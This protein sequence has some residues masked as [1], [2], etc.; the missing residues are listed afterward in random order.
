MSGGYRLQSYDEGGNVLGDSVIIDSIEVKAPRRPP[1]AA[2]L[3]MTQEVMAVFPEA[4]VTLLGYSQPPGQTKLPGQ[5][6]LVLFWRADHNHPA[7]RIR[8]VVLLDDSGRQAWGIS[9]VPASGSYPFHTWRAGEVVRD[10]VQFVAPGLE[11][12]PRDIGEGTHHFGVAVTV[13]E[14]EGSN[15]D[16]TIVP[17]GTVEFRIEGEM[18]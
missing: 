7:A 14:A 15:A 6:P 11:D 5:W 1:R 17:I 3:D 12:I 8:D 9:G 18:D 16:G 2:E 4:G 13:D 10:P